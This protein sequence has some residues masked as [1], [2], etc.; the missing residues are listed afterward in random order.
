MSFLKEL[1]EVEIEPNNTSKRV[2]KTSQYDLVLVESEDLTP[3]RSCAWPESC[4]CPDCCELRRKYPRPKGAEKEIFE[5][6]NVT[7][8]SSET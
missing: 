3:P 1:K 2:I 7:L 5:W 8:H 4:M 6:I